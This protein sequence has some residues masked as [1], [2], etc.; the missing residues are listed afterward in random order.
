MC[1]KLR[2]HHIV[3]CSSQQWY[4]HNPSD[5]RHQNPG[6]RRSR[7]YFALARYSP[8]TTLVLHITFYVLRLMHGGY[9]SHL[10]AFRKVAKACLLA[11]LPL[12]LP[13]ESQLCAISAGDYFGWVIMVRAIV[14]VLWFCNFG[15]M[16]LKFWH[17]YWC[18]LWSK[19]CLD[20]GFAP[21][22]VSLPKNYLLCSTRIFSLDEM[23]V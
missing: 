9:L 20:S 12:L 16:M 1:A 15:I 10:Q 14:D 2:Q 5:A 18:G 3:C 23:L 22:E 8:C 7:S 13:S 17:V 21:D 6:N 19:F 4:R 11:T